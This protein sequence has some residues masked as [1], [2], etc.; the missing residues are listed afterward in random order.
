MTRTLKNMPIE[1]SDL[2]TTDGHSPFLRILAHL[3]ALDPHFNEISTLLRHAGRSLTHPHLH[4]LDMVDAPI[5]G[6][7]AA[8]SVFLLPS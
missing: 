7:S 1:Q 5:N 3:R 4:L 8:L 6:P 2:T